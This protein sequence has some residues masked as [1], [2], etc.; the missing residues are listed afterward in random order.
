MVYTVR[1]L[2]RTEVYT[3]NGKLCCGATELVCRRCRVAVSVTPL[4]F[5]FGLWQFLKK[6]QRSVWKQIRHHEYHE[7]L[8][9]VV[10][11]RSLTWIPFLWKWLFLADFLFL[12][13]RVSYIVVVGDGV[14]CVFCS[15]NILYPREDREKK[16]LLYACRNCDHQVSWSCF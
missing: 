2:Q 12:Q 16:V 6:Q 9:R 4:L 11:T 7:V 10:S 8:P 3:P 14:R 15:N 13:I 5:R 1:S